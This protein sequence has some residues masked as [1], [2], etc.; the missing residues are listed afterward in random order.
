MLHKID[1]H[2]YAHTLTYV[3][4]DLLLLIHTH[5]HYRDDDMISIASQM[6]VSNLSTIGFL[7]DDEDDDM[8][9]LVRG[10]GGRGG[11]V[12]NGRER[13]VRKLKGNGD[14]VWKAKRGKKARAW[15]HRFNFNFQAL[16]IV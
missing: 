15:H 4:T 1:A 7:E 8:L 3:H 16:D 12:E 9:W 14:T 13:I 6:S 11:R 2:S 10:V 5:T